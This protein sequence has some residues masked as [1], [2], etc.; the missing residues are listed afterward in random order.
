MSTTTQPQTFADLVVD[1]QNRSREQAGITAT[2]NIAKRA[3]QTAHYD[4]YV[5]YGEKFSWAERRDYI[6]THAEYTTGTLTATQG[7]Q[8]I[9]GASTA[10]NTAN[11]Q[12]QN[13]MRVGGKVVISG[14]DEV[15]EVTAV[16]SDTSAT[17]S[18]AYIGTTAAS[19][20]YRYFED[21]YALATDFWKP[22]DARSFDD[23]RNIRLVGRTD[24]R[25]YF[26]NNRWTTTAIACATII[27]RPPSGNTTPIRKILFGP[28][29]SNVQVIPYSYVTKNLVVSSAGVAQEQFS[30]DAD[31]PI[32]PIHYRHVI[33]LGALA[34][35]MRDR[36]DDP[37][38]TAI[39][40]ERDSLLA[41]ML[42]D[43]DIGASTFEIRFNRASYRARARRPWRQG[44]GRYDINS[45]FDR[46]Q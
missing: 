14:E 1:L 38:F 24:F 7:N 8:T 20:S 12:G 23:H 15:Y 35:W 32:L 19:L 43:Q 33:V 5:G 28:A 37:R 2:D 10:W 16:A 21:E 46:F 3:I 40:Q 34:H 31:E 18:P 6:R 36:K 17:I 4:L 39:Q 9:T 22:V 26:P 29:P 30:A 13:N 25:R 11:G 42:D 27:D 44:S 45:R 41:R